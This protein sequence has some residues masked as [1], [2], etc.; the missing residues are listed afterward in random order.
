MY[1]LNQIKSK[2]DELNYNFYD[3]GDYNVN[4]IGVRSNKLDT[5]SFNDELY[6]IYKQGNK[7]NLK[8]YPITTDP[9][10]QSLENPVNVNGCAILVPGQYVGAYAIGLHK[11]QYEA[12]RQVGPVKVYRDNNLDKHLDFNK[13]SIDE[14]L[15]GINI[16]KSGK[17]SIIVDNWSAGCQVFK[18]ESDF[19][20]FMEI[21]RIA[22]KKWGN[23]FTYTLLNQW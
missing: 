6:L 13:D 21:I 15:F 18:T 5:N 19:N 17:D 1:T 3:T 14:G 10:F 23:S 8:C 20:E 4:I 12:L 16:H 2:L 11:G 7:W 22:A 9:G